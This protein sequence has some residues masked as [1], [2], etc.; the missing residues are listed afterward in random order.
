MLKFLR[1]QVLAFILPFISLAVNA[2]VKIGD[3]PLDINANSLLELESNTKGLLLPRLTSDQIAAMTNVPKGMLV[4]NSTDSA[5]FLR[6]DTGWVILSLASG[7][8]AV[9]TAWGTNGSSIYNKNTGKV[10]IG[11]NTPGEKFTVVA[12]GKGITQEN[13][14]GTISMGL[15][16]GNLTAVVQ[17]N[18]N[19][20]L[21]FA[22]NNS[23]SSMTLATNGNFG[24]GT[25][26]PD[27]RLHVQGNI[28]ASG[29]ITASNISYSGNLDM[30]L[31]YV[32]TEFSVDGH[33]IIGRSKPCPAGTK[34][35]GGGG[36]HIISNPA[37]DDVKVNFT[38]PEASTNSWR[39][40]ITNTSG[41][42]RGCIIYAICAKVE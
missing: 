37:A 40:I 11:T 23:A 2:Q 38:G 4:F 12:T 41:D 8:D 36:G 39:I 3:H 21:R 7:K 9:T 31:Q 16:T 5:L 26:S 35:I 33:K 20:P 13:A 22:T 10:G 1:L 25:S 34:V 27:E 24:I 6:R 42:S 30:G 15:F 14:A 17:T 29:N 28:K 19:H 18:T 32:S